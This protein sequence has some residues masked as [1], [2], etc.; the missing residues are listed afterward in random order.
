MARS[1]VCCWDIRLNFFLQTQGLRKIV[2]FLFYL[3]FVVAL[4]Q[5]DC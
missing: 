2:F 1:S 3:S 5:F 4:L